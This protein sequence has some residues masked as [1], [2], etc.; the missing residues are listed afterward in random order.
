MIGLRDRA[1]AEIDRRRDWLV[2]LCQEIVRRPTENPPGTTTACA[3]LVTAELQARGLPVERFEP[4]PELVSLVSSVGSGDPHFM[5]NGHMDVFPADDAALWEVPPFGGLLRDGRIYG[6]GVADMKGGFT[7]SLAS[8]LLIRDLGLPLR[9]RLS[10]MAVADEETGGHWGTK[11]LL[12]QRADLR[13]DACVIGEPCSTDAVRVGEKGVS[14]IS[15]RS[16][17]RSYHG[18]LAT[19]DNAITRLAAA[20]GIIQRIVDERGQTPPDLVPVIEGA[21]R[22]YLNEDYKGREWLLELDARA[23]APLGSRPAGGGRAR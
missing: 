5:L 17:G 11:W 8:Y 22:H 21:K 9:G 10:F 14:W 23:H 13:P 1:W 19:G 18:S 6:R 3:D 2:G 15:V 4:R 16:R 20:I 12:D 7:A